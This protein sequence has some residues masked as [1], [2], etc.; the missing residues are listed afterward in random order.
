M[1]EKILQAI[2]V[3]I[4]KTFGVQKIDTS[5][6]TVPPKKELGDWAFPCFQIAKELKQSPAQ[7]ATE[8][9]NK[10]SGVT[11]PYVE[12]VVAAGPYLNFFLDGSAVA[13]LTLTMI[14]KQQNRF[15]TQALSTEKTV[16]VEFAHPNTH[17]AFHI[18][19]LRNIIT[20]ESIVRLLENSGYRV[21]RANYQGDV[22]MH[23]AKCLWA[24]NQL[25][26]DYEAVL[27]K[28]IHEKVTFLGRAYAYGSG[29]FEESETAK[30]EIVQYNEKIYLKSADIL[31]V[32]T[33]TRAWSLEYFNHIYQ[34]VH[35]HF[36]RLYFESEVY[37]RGIEIVQEHLAK[38]VFVKSEGAVIFPGSQYD[39]HDR[40]FLNSKGYPTYEAK[41]LALAE[42]QFQ[43]HHP[44]KIIHVV[45]KEQ[46]E[47]FKVMFRALE[48]VLPDSKDKEKH[49]VY[50]WVA[51]KEGKMSSRT[52][53]VV[54]GEWLLDEVEKSIGEIMKESEIKNPTETIA[55]IA[56]SA[57]KYS[58]LKTGVHNDIKFD[59][60]ES[61]SL[62]GDSG[63]YL[64][65]IGARIK[66][67]LRKAGDTISLVSFPAEIADE[68]K[69]L[70]LQLL[71]YP[72]VT[73]LAAE[74]LDPSEVAKY[75]LVLAQK[76]NT[77]YHAC[78]VLVSEGEV[79]AFRLALLQAVLST[80][81]QG[82]NLL[83]IEPVQEM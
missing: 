50:G 76:F 15:G 32:Y 22:G 43:E 16:M 35:S 29:K 81:E 56:L 44:E 37:A 62:S 21:I 18:G 48:E 67:I 49:L 26:T 10:L 80:M 54:L 58:F 66:S 20:G 24:I 38:G 69:S 14:Q 9:A 12:R 33:T 83:G 55:K 79:L 53:Q 42:L 31:G 1:K 59:L 57:V 77:F 25:K 68:E 61:V 19:H 82:L 70:C 71:D 34:R 64:L 6:V 13:E 46:T 45:A 7:V 2:F 63:P 39:L 75:L 60:E 72:Q 4:E 5:V 51:L 52:G 47:Y 11:L 41:D 28:T 30:A 78:P 17:K 40:V 27:D 65:Y 8:W 36:D 74:N 23:I 3:E 73:K